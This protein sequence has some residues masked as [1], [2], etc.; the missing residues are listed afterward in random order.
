[1]SANACCFAI[2][3]SCPSL[4]ESTDT[5][6][7]DCVK[8]PGNRSGDHL[9][10]GEGNDSLVGGAGDDEMVGGAGIDTL[11]GGAGNDEYYVDSADKIQEDPNGG[12]DLI[13]VTFSLVMPD[14]IEDAY[15]T[16][17][18]LTVTGNGLD[19]AMFGTTGAD[20]MNGAS[21]N[22]VIE[23]DL[24][25]DKLSGGG[26]NDQF[27]YELDNLG[28]LALLGG[29]IITDFEVGKDTIDLYNLFSQFGIASG[30]PIGEGYLDLQVI[31]GNTNIRFDSNGGGDSFVTLATL[32]G[33]TT[34]TLADIIHPQPNVVI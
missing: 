24:G 10:G 21:G 19:N 12:N 28:D 3:Q 15:L 17:S 30:D 4:L 18:G 25:A 7:C 9:N 22:D 26:G 5:H 23:G 11:I 6:G 16:V 1:M 2:R 31:G 8:A 33:V 13:G 34:A 27:R 29:D 20:T 32:Q 14:N